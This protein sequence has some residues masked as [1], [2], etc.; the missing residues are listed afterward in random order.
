MNPAGCVLALLGLALVGCTSA[1]PVPDDSFY[2]L[3]MPELEAGRPLDAV[4][5]VGE[6]G[7]DAL[8]GERAMLYSSDPRHA[9]LQQ[10]H[11]HFWADPPPRL[12]RDYLV[13]YLRKADFARVVT[14]Y[15]PG[16][17]ADYVVSGRIWRFEQLIEGDASEAVVRLEIQVDRA[18][19][20]HPLLLREYAASAPAASPAPRDAA[21][22]F[23]QAL[24]QIATRFLRDLRATLG[25]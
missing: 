13:A 4:L 10:Y 14:R 19:G 11:Y 15:E 1:P 24:E 22:A 7:S 20:G 3:Q 6:L 18:R 21:V 16:V 9:V 23:G 5:A 2:R 25:R 12:L 8:H 17:A